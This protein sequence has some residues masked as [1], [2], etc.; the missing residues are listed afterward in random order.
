MMSMMMMKSRLIFLNICDEDYEYL[1]H[2]LQLI[3]F[4]LENR[5][6][7]NNFESYYCDYLKKLWGVKI[8]DFILYIR[9]GIENRL[10]NKITIR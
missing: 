5:I 7:K 9:V 1:R 2:H 10:I 8:L 6:L 4:I 3:F